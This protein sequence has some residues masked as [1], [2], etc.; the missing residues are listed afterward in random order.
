MSKKLIYLASMVNVINLEVCKTYSIRSARKVSL[1]RDFAL[2]VYL[3]VACSL[4]TAMPVAYGGEGYA[5]EVN[6]STLTIDDDEDALR[7]SSYTYE[8]WMKDL[9]GP[10]GSWR[11]VFCKGPGDV[12]AGRGPLLALRPNEPGLHFSHSTGAAQETANTMEGILVNEWT[13]IALVLTD[14]NGEQIIYQDG[15]EVVSESAPSLTD[16]T[17]SPVLRIGIGANV[18]LDDFRIWNY[19]RTQAEIEA[20]MNREVSGIE[21]GLVGYWR[22]NEGEGTTASDS[23][24]APVIASSPAP[25]NGAILT[26]TW[27]SLGWRSGDGAASQDVYFGENLNDVDNGAGDTFRGN[28]TETFFVVGFPGFPYPDGLITGKTYYWRIDGVEAD[29]TTKHKGDIWNFTVPPKTAYLPDPADG[30]QSVDPAP[31]LR[32]TGGF[33]AKLHHVYFGD[34]FDDVNNAAGALPQGST[35][36]SPG[37]LKMAKTY[38]WRV[39]EFDIVETH[40]GNVWSFTTE[41]AVESLDPADGA[42][43]ITQTPVLTW[44]P[45]VFGASHEVYFGTDAGAVKN[46]DTSSPEYKGSGDLGSESYDP[47]QL[48]WNTTYYWRVDEANSTNPDS[49]WT[50]PLWSFTTAN[51]LIIDDFESYNDLDPPDPQSNRIFE[52]WLDGYDIPTNGALVGNELPPYA[53]QSIVHS[54]IQSMPYF[55][56]NSVGN[57]EATLTLTSNNDWT[58]KGVNSLTIWYR[59]DSTNA[60]ENLYVALNDSAVVNHDNPDAAQRASWTEWKIDLQAFADQG[61]DLVNITSITIGLG[62]R[63]NPVAGGAGMLYFDDIRLYALAP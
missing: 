4:L 45:G 43:G 63:A 7:L 29:G 14:L 62:N 16:A 47:G 13:H 57:S 20:D 9:E 2:A 25:A 46:A 59:G 8:F 15:I 1:F 44:T 21:D 54:G 49:P 27:V 37:T 17:Q 10:T 60:A 26:D 50:G 11:N 42:V 56:D 24:A 38:Y 53:E 39:D 41:G 55:Y 23:I 40:K 12:N 28:Q 36:Y 61:V 34:T 31:V 19:A 52:A 58:V 6:G 35:D 32:W 3:S 18:A 30:A 22:F 48:E 5:L 33:G 51:F